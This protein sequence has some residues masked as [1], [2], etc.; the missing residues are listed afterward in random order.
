MTLKSFARWVFLCNILDLCTDLLYLRT[1]E[2]ASSILYKTAVG[3]FLADTLGFGLL[4]LLCFC[5]NEVMHIYVLCDKQFELSR[6]TEELKETMGV[7]VRLALMTGLDSDLPKKEAIYRTG[8][9][10]H[11]FLHSFPMLVL[12]SV[13]NSMTFTWLLFNVISCAS[14]FSMLVCGVVVS[15]QTKEHLL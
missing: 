8:V 14:S 11:A 2:F 10:V 1:Q 4:F 7:G 12:Q 13:N 3:I 6:V 5:L 15:V 9:L